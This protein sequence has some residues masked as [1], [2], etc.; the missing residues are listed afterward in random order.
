MMDIQVIKRLEHITL[1]YPVDLL[2]FG[3]KFQKTFALPPMKHDFE[4][5]SEWLEVD[6]DG[7]NYNVSKPYQEGTLQ[8]WDDTTPEGCNLGIVLSIHKDHPFVHDNM[9]VDN[10]VANVCGQIAKV[11][12]TVVYHHRTFTFGID[13]SERKNVVFNP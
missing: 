8:E 2:T 5:E 4:N 10:M 3:A 1:K 9:W 13:K 11:F 7:I 12:D 6:L